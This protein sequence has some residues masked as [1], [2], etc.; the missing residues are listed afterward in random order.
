MRRTKH[1]RQ[2]FTL[3][4]LLVVIAI[5]G[6]L[7]GLLGPAV[8]DARKKS[9]RTTCLNN[10]KQLGTFCTG[11]AL[12]HSDRFPFGPG[13]APP[14]YESF[15]VLVNATP[16]FDPRILCSPAQLDDPAE[17]DDNGKIVLESNNVSYAYR[18][19]RT[20]TSS[21]PTTVLMSNDTYRGAPNETDEP[22]GHEGGVNV[23]FITGEAS[24]MPVENIGEGRSFPEGLVD[25]S[26]KTE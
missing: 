5:I 12:D 3:V 19:K 14:A 11:Y 26:G 2:G 24:F 13:K 22:Q 4:E 17:P 18:S 25:N 9:V 1:L 15:Q 23:F 8:M 10:L 21:K 20:T 7:V 16:N 6:A